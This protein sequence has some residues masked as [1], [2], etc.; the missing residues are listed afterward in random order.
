LYVR[1]AGAS[2]HVTAARKGRSVPAAALSI[3]ACCLGSLYGKYLHAG[4]K[5]GVEEARLP[6][7]GF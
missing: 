7:W 6:L 2:R 3:E 1:N 4:D 5:P